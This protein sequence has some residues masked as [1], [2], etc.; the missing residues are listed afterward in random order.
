MFEA[1]G[2]STAGF[3]VV[4]LLLGCGCAFMTGQAV[5]AT[6][7]PVSQA[8]GYTL[9]LGLADRFLIY[10]LFGG[11][12]LNPAGYI[13]DTVILQAAA[14]I[15]FMATRARKMV[16]QYPW[17]YER[18]GLFGWRERVGSGAGRLSADS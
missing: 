16:T 2:S 14:L 11:E 5:A 4:T 7:R 17:L 18:T 8:V 15:A 12:L 1:I 13:V 6:W 9:L 10:A 3:F